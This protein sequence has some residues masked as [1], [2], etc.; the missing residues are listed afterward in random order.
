MSPDV[1]SETLDEMG[2]Q[3]RKDIDVVAI[4]IK[5]AGLKAE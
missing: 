1:D 4:A 5:A 3:R 2:A